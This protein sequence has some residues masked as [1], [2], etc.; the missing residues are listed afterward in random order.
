MASQFP[1]G[2]IFA[3]S[4]VLGAPNAVS[5]ITNTNPAVATAAAPVA[6]DSIV[7]INSNWPDLNDRIARTDNAN[8]NSFELLGI[9]T[10]NEDRYEPGEGDGSVRVASGFVNLSQVRE[11]TKSGGEQQFFTWQYL[12]DRSSRQRQR[13]TFKNAKVI[14]LTLDYDPALAWYEALDTLDKAQ[15]LVVLRATLPNGAQMFYP[16]Y[17]SFDADPSLTMNENMTNVATFSLAGDFTR[18]EPTP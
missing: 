14:N 7:L 4:T 2:T 15:E 8:S 1:N 9:D 13:P 17:P 10:T 5:G 6:D 18:Y 16:V 3:V 11:S 12:E